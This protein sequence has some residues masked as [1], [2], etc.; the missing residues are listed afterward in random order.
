MQDNN[1]NNENF[2]SKQHSATKDWLKLMLIIN[3]Q[4]KLK[5]PTMKLKNFNFVS[6]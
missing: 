6:C 1:E 4:N 5:S 2:C 3:R